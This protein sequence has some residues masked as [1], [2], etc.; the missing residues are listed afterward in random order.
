M[1][2]RN[3]TGE[4]MSRKRELIAILISVIFIFLIEFGLLK[5]TFNQTLIG[6]LFIRAIVM[7]IWDD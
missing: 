2:F 3:A 6:L 1:V 5:Q 7:N 4:T